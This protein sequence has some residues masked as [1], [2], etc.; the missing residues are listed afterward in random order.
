M[1]FVLDEDADARVGGFLLARGH[2]VQYSRAILGQQAPDRLVVAAAD[3]LGAIVVTRNTK[4]FR[5]L[6]HRDEPGGPA[7]LFRRAGLICF[8]CR[9]EL[10]MQ[11]VEAL[12]EA[13]EQEFDRCLMLHDPRLIVEIT[14]RTMQI[15]R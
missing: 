7:S 14:D 12:I 10:A 3:A 8:R 13:L 5:S 6:I 4:H 1:H 2:I 9:D 11:R 15:V